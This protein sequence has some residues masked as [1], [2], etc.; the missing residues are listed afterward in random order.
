MKDFAA[1]DLGQS[2]AQACN[3]HAMMEHLEDLQAELIDCGIMVSKE[4]PHTVDNRR[5]ERERACWWWWPSDPGSPEGGGGED[6]Q[7]SRGGAI[8]RVQ[9]L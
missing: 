4:D 2:R 9:V 3:E 8:G 5:G 6:V 1:E 7:H